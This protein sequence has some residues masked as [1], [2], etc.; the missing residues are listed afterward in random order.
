MINFLARF[1]I[2][3]LAIVVAI[4]AWQFPIFTG[5]VDES[6]SDNAVGQ[7]QFDGDVAHGVLKLGEG[8][9][10]ALNYTFKVLPNPSSNLLVKYKDTEDVFDDA[11]NGLGNLFV[12]VLT[13][14]IINN[15]GKPFPMKDI[16]LEYIDE[17]GGVCF[18]SGVPKD[19]I[20]LPGGEY[21]PFFFLSDYVVRVMNGELNAVTLNSTDDQ[22]I[23]ISNKDN[24]IMQ[25]YL[26][27]FFDE[28][29]IE[30]NWE[31]VLRQIRR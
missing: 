9:V 28:T 15:S 5:S 2:P 20:L 31:N 8:G 27:L 10:T 24:I 18:V 30:E 11:K 13:F 26:T 25:S 4:L 29:M 21:R 12:P 1:I 16:C 22:K 23:S 6:T 14:N 19:K 17:K 7:I 3:A